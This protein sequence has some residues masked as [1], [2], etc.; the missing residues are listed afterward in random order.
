MQRPAE[1]TDLLLVAL[2]MCVEN[3][4]QKCS[5]KVRFGNTVLMSFWRLST[6]DLWVLWWLEWVLSVKNLSRSHSDPKSNVMPAQCQYLLDNMTSRHA[7][8]PPMRCGNNIQRLR[9]SCLLGRCISFT[10]MGSSALAAPW[11][12]RRR[13][14]KEGRREEC[15]RS[16]RWMTKPHGEDLAVTVAALSQRAELLQWRDP[17]CYANCPPE[18]KT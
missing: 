17:D 13:Y 3:V 12:R 10:F 8:P 1:L 9:P 7:T 6:Q 14:N 5:S 15:H 16:V 11:P 4:V 18:E 2:V